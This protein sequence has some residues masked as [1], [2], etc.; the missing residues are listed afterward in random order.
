[1]DTGFGLNG[2][3][4]LETSP[5]A[6]LFLQDGAMDN[7]GRLLLVGHSLDEIVVV[8]LREDGELDQTFGNKGIVRHPISE[9]FLAQGAAVVASVNKIY[10][11]GTVVGYS[12]NRTL[13]MCLGEHG[14]LDDEFHNGEGYRI[15]GFGPT[16]DS[17]GVDITATSNGNIYVVSTAFDWTD[18]QGRDQIAVAVMR[19]NGSFSQGF[20]GDG[21]KIFSPVPGYDSTAAG[22]RVTALNRILIGG[23]TFGSFDFGNSYIQGSGFTLAQLGTNG[24]P[25]LPF[26]I[27]GVQVTGFQ[28]AGRPVADAM[29][30][31]GREIFLVGTASK[32]YNRIAITTYGPD[33]TPNPTFKQNGKVNVYWPARHIYGRGIQ[34]MPGGDVIAAGSLINPGQFGACRLKLSGDLDN[35]FGNAGLVTQTGNLE[36]AEPA[37]LS[38]VVSSKTHHYLIGSAI[39]KSRFDEALVIDEM[40][41]ELSWTPDHSG[42]DRI[43]EFLRAFHKSLQYQ[44]LGQVRVKSFRVLDRG[45]ASTIGAAIGHDESP[46]NFDRVFLRNEDIEVPKP[47]NLW[48]SIHDGAPA[49]D[50][51]AR[52][53]EDSFD[54]IKRADEMVI[55]WAESRFGPIPPAKTVLQHVAANSNVYS[56]P[57]S[58]PPN[59]P[60][61]RAEMVFKG[62][63]I[64]H[65]G[66][67]EK[68][69]VVKENGEAITMDQLMGVIVIRT[70]NSRLSLGQSMYAQRNGDNN[71]GHANGRIAL[72]FDWVGSV[73]Y[74][75]S[76]FEHNWKKWGSKALSNIDDKDYGFG[77]H[78]LNPLS[79]STS[80]VE[81]LSMGKYK[82]AA[83]AVVMDID[84]IVLQYH[85]GVRYG[86]YRAG[87]KLHS[88]VN[89]FV[90]KIGDDTYNLRLGDYDTLKWKRGSFGDIFD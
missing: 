31:R 47:G 23:T 72:E 80:V 69:R 89:D 43:H 46:A 70:N 88:L 12:R 60:P 86:G 66:M 39:I 10:V 7:H 50:F 81:M 42:V 76:S 48:E 63:E 58:L 87:V 57:I 5:D 62:E 24:Q 82:F 37:D 9:G 3:L 27:N 45:V 53:H 21:R 35:G 75:R 29:E 20:S 32:E 13:V 67:K 30:I 8:R 6:P 22:I 14:Q 90:I 54:L 52:I 36:W 26:G 68:L 83:E 71:A 1:M 17:R 74:F 79:N 33:G 15:I 16:V 44:T 59:F 38:D 34:L 64:L 85:H 73:D 25:D 41:V 49:A 40:R 56:P 4:V 28:Q 19:A 55:A 51:K 78:S 11:V 18:P 65:E 61:T 84:S 2:H 77:I